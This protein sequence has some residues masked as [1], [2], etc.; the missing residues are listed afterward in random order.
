ML[1]DKFN[2]LNKIK[3]R[4]GQLFKCHKEKV[5]FIEKEK[6]ILLDKETQ[7]QR[8][9][10]LNRYDQDKTSVKTMHNSPSK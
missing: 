1:R 8:S 6:R 4:K 7:T 2:F 5:I 9:L 10:T 3:R